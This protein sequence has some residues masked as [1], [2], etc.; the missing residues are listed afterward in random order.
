[1]SP[2]LE[3]SEVECIECHRHVHIE[4]SISLGF[5]DFIC[6]ECAAAID[7]ENKRLQQIEY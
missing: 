2:L 1:M 4:G 6:W 5:E 7:E 3:D